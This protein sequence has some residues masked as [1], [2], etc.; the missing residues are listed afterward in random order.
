MFKVD[1]SSYSNKVSEPIKKPPVQPVPLQKPNQPVFDS[2]IG[3]NNFRADTLKV[4][5]NK[6]ADVQQSNT[7]AKTVKLAPYEALDKINKLPVPS[8]NDK[9]ATRAYQ[10]QRADIADAALKTATPPKRDDFKGLPG[11][12][13]GMEYQDSLS[14]YNS[15]I[16]SLKDVSTAANTDLKTQPTA[17]LDDSA[18]RVWDAGKNNPQEGAKALAK[19]VDNINAKYGAQ[20]GGQLIGKLYQDSKD[21]NY[22]H[23]LNNILTFAGGKETNGLGQVGLPDAQRNSIGTAIGQ[24]YDKM[25]FADRAD[26]VKN[27]VAETEGDSFRGNV[28]GGDATRIANLISRSDSAALKN[29][30]VNALTK[31]MGEIQPGFLG[32]NGGTDIKALA[33]SAAIIAGSGADGAAQTKM[34]DTIIKSFPDM[35]GDQFKSLT[36]DPALKDNLSKV[37]INNSAAITKSLTNEAG[38]LLDSHSSDGLRQFFEM[39]MFSKNPGQLREQMM[40]EAVKLISKF[41]DP[42]ALS[43]VGRTKVDDART[44]GSLIGLVQAAA[45]NQKGAIQ[46]DQKSRDETTKMFVGMAFAF[47][48]GA[49]KVLGEGSGKLLE[50]AYGKGVDFAKSHAESGLSGVINNLADGDS[51]KKID[52][53]FKAIRDLR[54]QASKSLDGEKDNALYQ[55]FNEGYTETGVDQLF[56]KAFGK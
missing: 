25:S 37:L 32:N 11:R 49:S 44:A 30:S 55:A 53:G 10:Q 22:D 21:G 41:A 1:G 52:E 12:L 36:D 35:D 47:A 27:A 8:L 46:D 56:I 29:D 24:A 39:A 38:G 51:L 9:T 43:S 33:N 54:F 40:G 31:R 5:L 15:S 3:E 4:S 28:L 6:L 19:E 20:A 45:I 48:P 2:K 26:F 42:S 50:F 18:K 23:N 16:K 13:A 14:S 17:V 34:F 7:A